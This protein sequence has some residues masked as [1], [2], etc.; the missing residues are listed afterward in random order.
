MKKTSLIYVAGHTGLVGSAIIRKLLASGYRNLLLKTHR[1]LDLTNQQANVDFL[2]DKRPEYLFLCA[3]RVGGI[4]ANSSFP[5][6]FVYQNAMIEAN[7][8][9]AAWASGVK[10]LLY[11]GCS[12]MYPKHAVNP[13]R[14]EALLTGRTEP[15]NEPYAVAKILGVEL[16]QAYNRQYGTRFIVAIPSNV[17]GVG[18]RHFDSSGHVVPGLINSF[19]TAK[20]ERL[21]A[22]TVWGS[23]KPKRDFLYVDDL[24]DA[25]LFLIGHYEASEVVNVGTG[26]GVSIARLARIVKKTVGFSGKIVYDTQKPDGMP[27]RVIDIRKIRALGWEAKTELENGLKSTYEWYKQKFRR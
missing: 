23:G 13:I 4:Y 5:A 18:E 10:K 19:E 9:N 21:P 11:L 6:E 14:E 25:C 20:Q 3:A 22:V 27:A 17:Y 15:T 1:E 16:C 2:K 26:Q 7:V 12:C 8:I 24:A